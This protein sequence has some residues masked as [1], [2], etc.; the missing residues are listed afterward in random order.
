[1]IKLAINYFVKKFYVIVTLTARS[2][3]GCARWG[4]SVESGGSGDGDGGQ[5]G[6]H[7][8][9]GKSHLW[10]WV[11]ISWKTKVKFVLKK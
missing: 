2:T 10:N 11:V 9:D 8:P 7:G 4:S 3:S 6:G 1:M 5:G